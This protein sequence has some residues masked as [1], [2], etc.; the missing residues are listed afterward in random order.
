MG[1]VRLKSKSEAF[2][3]ASASD[4][5]ARVSEVAARRE[6]DLRVEEERESNWVLVIF[7]VWNLG[8]EMWRRETLGEEV[9]VVKEREGHVGLVEAMIVL[10]MALQRHR[11]S[12]KDCGM[13]MCECY[14]PQNWREREREKERWFSFFF[15][16][17]IVFCVWDFSGCRQS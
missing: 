17:V 15:A 10:A 13:C 9:G 16:F 6:R 1:K 8:S 5:G 4:G 11:E 2:S 14:G 7:G 3:I 12:V